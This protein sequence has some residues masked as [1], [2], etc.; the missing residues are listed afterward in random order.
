MSSD[1]AR[2]QE[3]AAAILRLEREL[4]RLVDRVAAL[5]AASAGQGATVAA[6]PAV[7]PEADLTLDDELVT[8][9][10]AAV[11]AWLG[12]RAGIRQI[13]LLGSPTWAQQGRVTIHASHALPVQHG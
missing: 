5:E 1:S 2:E 3:Q 13:R 6:S 10:G 8:V 7:Q 9:L 11:A 12:K 4:A